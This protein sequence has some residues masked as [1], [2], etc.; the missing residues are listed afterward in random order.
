ML[1]F[2]FDPNAT[3]FLKIVKIQSRRPLFQKNILT[4][5]LRVLTSNMPHTRSVSI[6]VFV[7]AGSRYESED[8]AG[9][10]HFLEHM[11][12]KGSEKRP[13]PH[14]IS[15]PIESLGGIINASTDREM[16]IYWIKIAAEHF[17]LAMDVLSDMLQNP[18]LS[19]YEHQ[20]EKNV[21]LE[22]LAMTYDQPDAY[23]DML[24]DQT[25]WPNQPMGRDVGGTKDSVISIS[26]NSLADYHNR[27]YGPENSV[28][29]IAG[30]IAHSVAINETEKLFGNWGKASPLDWHRVQLPESNAP[31]VTIGNRRTDQAHLALAMNGVSSADP[32]K[33][34]MS[35]L[36]TILGEGMSSR[37]FMEMREKRGLA[38]DVASHASHYKDCGALTAYCGVDPS[39][40]DETLVVLQNELGKISID[41]SEEELSNAQ[42]FATGRLYLRLEDTRAVMSWLG[43]QELLFN[44]VKTPEKV[45][46]EVR[47][48]TI[49]D[50]HSVA[51]EFLD[52]RFYKLAIV[53]PYRSQGRFKKL[54]AA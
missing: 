37:L 14:L 33:Y 25:L 48:V 54:L 1:A 27:Q 50:I 19:E 18:L 46:D 11:L 15:G 28:I 24:I 17:S 36:N 20:R 31:R 47:S 6:G 22:E 40:I 38:Y 49:G 5:G 43:G 35:L 16:T 23:A 4:N 3:F 44:E 8:L 45:V 9:A 30:N 7:G 34:S 32:R 21:I 52:P 53:G 42:A 29:A 2:S 26:K 39:K 12:F 10:S 41:A 51:R 13:S